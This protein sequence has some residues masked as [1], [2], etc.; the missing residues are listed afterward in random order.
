VAN[1]DSAAMKLNISA[2]ATGTNS[3]LVQAIRQDFGDRRR[4]NAAY[5]LRSYARALQVDQSLLSK[6]LNGKVQLSAKLESRLAPRFVS[7]ETPEKAP[8]Q[9]LDETREIK[10]LSHWLHFAILEFA[11]IKNSKLNSLEVSKRFAVHKIEAENAIQLLVTLGFLESH[12]GQWKLRKNANHTWYHSDKTTEA[13]RKYQMDIH[14]LSLR[15]IEEVPFVNREHGSLTLAIAAKRLPELKEYLR[16]I[17]KEIGAKFQTSSSELDQVFQ[18][19]FSAF[20]LSQ[21]SEKTRSPT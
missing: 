18:F 17:R 2:E 14:A 10:L 19:T 4:K 9:S 6:I 20:P 16:K 13:R 8:F 11:K 7:A 5:S 3:A 21:A 12:K 1:I 15:A